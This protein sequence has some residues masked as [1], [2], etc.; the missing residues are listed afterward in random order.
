MANGYLTHRWYIK[1][2]TSRRHRRR[3]H[4][5]PALSTPLTSAIRMVQ[6]RSAVNLLTPYARD[7]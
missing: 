6:P 7:A 5:V 1:Q 2:R 4:M 3:H